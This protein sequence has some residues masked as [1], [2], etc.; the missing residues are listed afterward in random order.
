MITSYE[1]DD[2][3]HIMKMN[4][5]VLKDSDTA[6]MNFT[7]QVSGEEYEINILVIEDLP[8]VTIKRNGEIKYSETQKSVDDLKIF[9]D[10]SLYRYLEE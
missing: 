7:H 3:L 6:Q 5:F 9:L 4:R 8:S 1:R 10:E 2:L